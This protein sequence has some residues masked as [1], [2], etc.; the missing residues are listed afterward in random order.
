MKSV[1]F[2]LRAFSFLVF[3]SGFINQFPILHFAV[4]QLSD[5][6]SETTLDSLAVHHAHIFFL[7]GQRSQILC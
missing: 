5:L 3:K 4:Y 6:P 7:Q 1:S 2:P